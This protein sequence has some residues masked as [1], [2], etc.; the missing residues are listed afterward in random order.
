LEAFTGRAIT[1]KVI[2][3]NI[4]H[5]SNAFNMESNAH[6]TFDLLAWGIEEDP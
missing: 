6:E 2:Q 3:A 5:P 4:D 1:A